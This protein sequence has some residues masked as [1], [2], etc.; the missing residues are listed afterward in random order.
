[1]SWQATS[2]AFAEPRSAKLSNA[3]LRVLM[4]LADNAHHDGT[5][6]WEG[7][8]ALAERLH[9]SERTVERATA[10]LQEVGLIRLGDQREVS[11]F[12]ADRRPVVWDLDMP[13]TRTR[14]VEDYIDL[15]DSP[16]SSQAPRADRQQGSAPSGPTG[17]GPRADRNAENGPTSVVGKNTLNTMNSQGGAP[18]SVTSPSVAAGEPPRRCMKHQG[19]DHDGPCG[20]CGDAR[21]AYDAWVRAQK[22]KPSTHVPQV[23]CPEHP[24]EPA[25]RCSRCASE[26]V[27][28]RQSLREMYQA[29]R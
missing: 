7:A 27:R 18:S 2:W 10:T 22:P 29:A 13:T 15:R 21:R 28:P 16:K 23:K 11:H 8:K 17:S 9:I 1:M 5:S 14:P 20:S 25:G 19:T 3:T 12:R 26:A 6:A 4:A 24:T